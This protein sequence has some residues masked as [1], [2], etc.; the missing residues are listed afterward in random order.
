MKVIINSKYE[1]T[2]HNLFEIHITN[3]SDGNALY[4]TFTPL[5]KLCNVSIV[6]GVNYLSAVN[7]AKKRRDQGQREHV[8]NSTP[9]MTLRA[10]QALFKQSF[11]VSDL[12]T[13]SKFT[14]QRHVLI[15]IIW[16]ETFL[17]HYVVIIPVRSFNLHIERN[18]GRSSERIS[19]KLNH[20]C[21]AV[22]GDK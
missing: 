4:T 19:T 20:V 18:Y 6:M 5:Q 11:G 8:T 3:N 9:A 13:Y 16:M 17:M 14:S 7:Y 21:R 1:A 2:V 22:I 15:W 10:R 12:K